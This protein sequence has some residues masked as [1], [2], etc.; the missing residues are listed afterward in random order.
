MNKFENLYI[1]GTSHISKQSIKEIHEAF[2]KIKPDFVAVE[3][4]R[5]RLYALMSPK[6]GKPS[7]YDIR[8]IGLKGFLFALIGSWAAKKLGKMVG[9]MP[10][11]EMK[12]AIMLAKKNKVKIALIDQHIEVTLKRFSKKLSW[13]ERWRLLVDL[14]KGFVLRKKDPLVNFDLSKVPSNKLIRMMLEKIKER[15]PNIHKVLIE[16]RNYYMARKLKSLMKAHQDKKILAVIGAGH[17]EEIL[18]ILK[19]HQGITYSFSVKA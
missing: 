6:Q 19:E 10:G 18:R 2:S 15:Y 3:L 7:F 12:S 1:I 17:E 4:D 5:N 8:R 13:K 11:D 16:E 9:V 14:F